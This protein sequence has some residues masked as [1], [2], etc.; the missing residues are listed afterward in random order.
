MWPLLSSVSTSVILLLLYLNHI[1]VLSC[2]T[3]VT[4]LRFADPACEHAARHGFTG[5]RQAEHTLVQR[6]EG[7]QGNLKICIISIQKSNIKLLLQQKHLL[8]L[9]FVPQECL[10]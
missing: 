6:W 9:Q 1:P 3:L 10:E 5:R 2:N 4:P 8:W 7:G